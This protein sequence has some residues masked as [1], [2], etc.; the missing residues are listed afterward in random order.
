MAF[1]AMRLTNFTDYSLRVLIY[2]GLHGSG[3]ASIADIARAY[4]IKQNHLTKVVNN[5]TRLGYVE[6]VRG[7][8]GGLRLA[9]APGEINLREIVQQTED[10]FAL[11]QCFAN[12]I[13]KLTG[14]CALARATNEALA[15][16]FCVLERFTLAD[17]VGS[18]S[19]KLAQRLG[20]AARGPPRRRSDAP[21]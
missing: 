14:V 9:K 6:S 17:L 20:L 5:L 12:D 4:Q 19:A 1:N 21:G 15:A 11:V 18:D 8:G 16:F 2:L 3:L 10:N 13:C 7:R